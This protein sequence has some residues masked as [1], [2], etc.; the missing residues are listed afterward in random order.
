MN[1]YYK[2][3]HSSDALLFECHYQACTYRS[4]RESNCKQH[5]KRAHGWAYIRCKKIG[6]KAQ[7]PTDKTVA[8][9]RTEE[10]LLRLDANLDLSEIDRDRNKSSS[11]QNIT[12]LRDNMKDVINLNDIGSRVHFQEIAPDELD[13][14]SGMSSTRHVQKSHNHDPKKGDLKNGET[15][16]Q[17]YDEARRLI[18]AAGGK[19]ASILEMVGNESFIVVD[20]SYSKDFMDYR[21]NEGVRANRA[22]KDAVNSKGKRGREQKNTEPEA[23]KAE[24]E[25]ELEVVSSAKEVKNGRLLRSCRRRSAG[26]EAKEPEAE[27]EPRLEHELWRAP[28]ARMY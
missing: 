23:N 20:T 4:K 27:T 8:H 14:D 9:M 1:K 7:S 28:V 19:Y 15:W 10:D 13:N 2:D 6:T 24:L 26:L 12:E 22:A 5:M 17:S 18:E 25:P 3:K 21:D 16:L 11:L